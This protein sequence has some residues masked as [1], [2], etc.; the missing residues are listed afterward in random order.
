MTDIRFELAPSGVE[1]V[2]VPGHVMLR[3]YDTS[4]RLVATLVDGKLPAGTHR[5]RFEK[6]T[7]PSGVYFY[8]LS[9]GGFTATKKMVV[10]K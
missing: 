3:V 9:T 4:G 8:R 2:P 5:V 10:L 1:A 7:N 6:G